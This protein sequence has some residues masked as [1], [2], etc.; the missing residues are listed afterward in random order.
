MKT[1]TVKTPALQ[2]IAPFGI[3]IL[4]FLA[5]LTGFLVSSK[6]EVSANYPEGT[7]GDWRDISSCST[8]QC[9][10]SEGTKTQEKTKTRE[11]CEKDC[12]TVTF[13]TSHKICPEG[14]PHKS[15]F[16][17]GY[18][19]KN[20]RGF[21]DWS[22]DYKAM[23]TETFT[24]T[25]K[26][27]KSD[28]LNK[29][30]KPTPESLGIPQ[31]A[32]GDYGKDLPEWKDSINVNCHQ[33]V[34]DIQNR[35]ISC[36]E[37]PIIA[38]EAEGQCPTYCGYK[39]GTVPDGKGGYKTCEST[40][41]CVEDIYGCTDPEAINY[42]PEA[43]K[44]DDSCEY[45]PGEPAP[46]GNG[47]G[48]PVGAPVCTNI[49][50]TAPTLN[51]AT[52]AGVNSILVRWSKVADATHY[53]IFYGPSSGN[54]PY[55]VPDTG[56]TDNFVINGLGSGCFAVKAV[57]NCAPGPLSNEVCTGRVLGA[58]NVLGA[59][60]LGATGAAEENIFYALFALGSLLSGVG[61]RKFASSKVR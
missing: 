18:C 36:N 14:Y 57:N 7:W 39:G 51:S 34:V 29:C 42:N 31:W 24:K 33:E 37:A 28:D 35:T 54:Y 9:G 38:C 8:D 52:S 46:T 25:F 55:S 6:L 26:Y 17:P 5:G 19:Y 59:S 40:Q 61:V 11:V 50:P 23:E 3:A 13:T 15:N 43:T 21:P 60:T 56:N 48:G 10:T 2:K 27:L 22:E 32:R 53:S 4:L 20:V 49:T 41:A 58:S 30:H 45:Q 44:D 47:V 1:G 16:Y 12:P